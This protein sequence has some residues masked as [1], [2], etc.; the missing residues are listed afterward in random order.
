MTANTG[1]FWFFA[2]SNV[3]VFVKILDTCR[4]SGKFSVYVNGLTHLG[5]TITV[6]DTQTG[7][8]KTFVNPEG[9]PFS[10][11]FDGETFACP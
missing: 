11:L 1:Y 10:L 8:S 6:T 3:E 4:E 9:A 5:V 2:P 7:T